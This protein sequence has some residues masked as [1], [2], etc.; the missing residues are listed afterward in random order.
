MREFRRIQ[1]T[2]LDETIPSARIAAQIAEV[3]H[4]LRLLWND[5]SVLADDNGAGDVVGLADRN[6]EPDTRQLLFSDIS[7]FILALYQVKGQDLG[8][9]ASSSCA[10][11]EAEVASVGVGA[12]GSGV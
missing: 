1:S 10:S 8:W 7:R 2:S 5:C 4:Y 9:S 3:D 11:V 6:V 12:G